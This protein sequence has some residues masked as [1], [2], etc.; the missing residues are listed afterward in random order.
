[1]QCTCS[2]LCFHRA[3][4]HKL[5]CTSFKCCYISFV[6]IM[7][8]EFTSDSLPYVR[9][10][11]SLE[12]LDAYYNL[13]PWTFPGDKIHTDHYSVNMYIR[14]TPNKVMTIHHNSKW[15]K[16]SINT[17]TLR[18]INFNKFLLKHPNP[19]Y[20]RTMHSQPEGKVGADNN[21]MLKVIA[22]RLMTKHGQVR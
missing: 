13:V 14:T 17:N 2:S 1:M 22:Q 8:G 7:E 12:I 21:K 10:L 15:W 4:W 19:I 6:C 18:D 9:K 11:L 3:I 16:I 20:K 5:L